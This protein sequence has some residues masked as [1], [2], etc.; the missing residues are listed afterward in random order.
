MDLVL[1]R[2]ADAQEPVP[3][4]DPSQAYHHD[5][6]RS[7]TGRGQKHAARMATWLD[8]QL[9]DNTRVLVSPALR[10]EQTAL[11]LG[12][13]FKLCESL[14]PERSAEDLLE[15]AQWPVAKTT[16]LVVG[17]QP[18]LGRVAAR[19]LGLPQAEL[20]VRKGAVWWLRS[21][22]REGLEQTVLLAVQSPDLL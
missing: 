9:P 21:R 16:V 2:H 15:L 22:E 18:T 14:A 20:S 3:S 1:W 13:K 7:L 10:C 8:H 11:N 6:A 19:L 4:S 12:R 5:L 17:H